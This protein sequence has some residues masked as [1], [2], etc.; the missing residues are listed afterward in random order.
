MNMQLLDDT[1]AFKGLLNESVP[2]LQAVAACTMSYCQKQVGHFIS[3]V[4]LL[5]TD[6]CI[7]HMTCNENA[8]LGKQPS[9]LRKHGAVSV[10]W[11][12]AELVCPLLMVRHSQIAFKGMLC[13]QMAN[14][15]VIFLQ[16][17]ANAHVCLL[18]ALL[19]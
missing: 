4:R 18:P 1:C 9:K 12:H 16:Q 7:W 13:K 11:R 14:L 3:L 19:C 8:Q 2:N 5:A 15:P 17:Q 6:L 10:C